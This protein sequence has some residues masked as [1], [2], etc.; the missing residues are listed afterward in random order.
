MNELLELPDALRA[1][2][3]ARLEPRALALLEQAAAL[4]LRLHADE[5]GPE[6]LLCA[7]M[8]DE[9]CAAHRAVV[10]AFADPE[11]LGEETL[12]LAAGILV[13]GS[14]VSLPFSEGAVQALRAA[15]A[16]ADAR[17]EAVVTPAHLLAAAIE[18]LPA[19]LREATADAGYA[20]EALPVGAP[21]RE[22]ARP[23]ATLAGSLFSTLSEPAKRVLSSAA[24]LAR[25]ERLAA[26]APVHL[27][28]ATLHEDPALGRACGLSAS[29]ARMLY[30]GRGEDPTPLPQR[31]LPADAP[32]EGFLEGLE[33]GT[34]SLGLLAR[35]HAG[36]TPELARVLMHHRIAPALIER[37][38][39]AFED[40]PA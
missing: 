24:R 19:D 3:T 40:P 15:R 21:P 13:C 12:A 31:A 27:A 7:L 20:P 29:R 39:G 17:E 26:I 30:R 9:D 34:Q 35:F 25:S 14:S 4:A 32:L 37:V 1:R 10:H 8:A 2:V 23:V 38:R 11:T 33:A 28:V 22:L 6:H 18:A 16:H 5:V 36:G